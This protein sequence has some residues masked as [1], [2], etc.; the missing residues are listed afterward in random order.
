MHFKQ[1]LSYYLL[2]LSVLLNIN[3]A[4][5]ENCGNGSDDDNDGLIDL[6]DPD[7][8]C[9]FAV[10]GNLLQN[11]SFEAF[12]HCP[13]NYTFDADSRMIT[14]WQY[15]TYTNGHEAQYY[16]NFSCAY[17]SSLVMGYIPP[18][19][20]LPDG[21]AFISIRQGIYRKPDFQER[22][23]AKTYVGQC[24]QAPLQP[25]VPYTITFNA[26][27]FQSNDDSAFKY[28]T[29]PMSIGLFGHADCAAVPFG[30]AY[31]QSNGCPANYPGWVQLGTTSLRS[32]GDW[33]QGEIHFTVPYAIKQI[34][35]GPDCSL[36]SPSTELTDST[37]LLDYYVYYLDDVHLL[38]TKELPLLYIQ[39]ANGDACAM[40][41]LLKAPVF[42]GGIYQWYQDS[43]AIE[44]A[45]AATYLVPAG[46][47]A[48]VYSVRLVSEG[49]CRI[50]EPFTFN[51]LAGLKL[52]PDTTF[53]FGDSVVLATR[54]NGVTYNINGRTRES[55]VLR[56][57][58]TYT[59]TAISGGCSKTFEVN[60]RTRDCEQGNL[61]MPNAFTPNGDGRNDVFRIPQEVNLNLNSFS[62]FDRWGNQV[63]YTTNSSNGWG[64]TYNGKISP[65]GTYVYFIK[66]RFG[67]KE[68]MLKGLVFLIR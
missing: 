42:A 7:C 29:E 50:S 36:L 53:C 6:K 31:A 56:Q 52:P 59:I 41:S 35:I 63:F 4:A 16:H 15:G 57:A 44:G 1:P 5:Q 60:V 27:R 33:V 61:Y 26:G 39:R 46:D 11:G 20:P 64:G 19:L 58:G 54:V 43:I 21:N 30:Q 8:Q 47:R 10:T 51:N 62:I 3:L 14:N 18:A 32:K 22:D 34:E 9:R 55:V 68:R 37:T 66:G 24:L 65:A 40:D 28:K 45:T 67:N 23:I 17:D 49:T 12:D 2:F 25:G 38:P 13:E 48:S